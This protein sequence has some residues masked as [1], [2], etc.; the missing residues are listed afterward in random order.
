VTLFC[1][2]DREFA[3]QLLADYERQAGVSVA[4]KYDTEAT[5]SVGLVEELRRDARRPRC[6]VFWNNEIVGTIRLQRAGLLEPFTPASADAL[7]AWAQAPDHTWHAFASRARVLLVNTQKVA[8]ADYPQSLFDLT[9]PKW[10]GQ[11]ALAKPLYGTTATQMACLFAVLGPEKAKAWLAALKANG[12]Q[13]VAGNKP[14]ALAVSSG[15]VA[16]ALTDTDDAW[17]ELAAGKPVAIVALDAHG[18]P[19]YPQLGT[20]FIPNTLAL[21]K[22]GPNP[23]AGRRLL[24]HLLRVETEQALAAGASKQIPLLAAASVTVPK[25]LPTPERVRAMAVDFSTAVDYWDATQQ[26]VAELFGTN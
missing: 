26:Y 10:K 6:D 17:G 2:Q 25:E 20:L 14:A 15:Q 5:K 24:E 23:T 18:H 12:V 9:H 1:A 4:I 3:E 8:P 11:L 21:I 7:P 13:I 16:L 19:D 22:G